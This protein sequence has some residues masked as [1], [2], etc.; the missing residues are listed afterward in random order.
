MF[1]GSEDV[2]GV[3]KSEEEVEMERVMMG[4]WAAFG[5]D[6]VGGLGEMGWKK[7]EVAGESLVRLGFGNRG[8]A[9]FAG[10]NDYDGVCG[11]VTV[12][13]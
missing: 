2:S 4:A 11:N 1:G 7:Y 13:G 6:P 3:V 8:E 5:R 9:T 12:E 10:V